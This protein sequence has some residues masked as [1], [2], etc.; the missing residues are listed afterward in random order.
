MADD[1]LLRRIAALED[2]DA[3]RTLKATYFAACDAKDAL[4]MRACFADGPVAIDYGPVGCFDTA[5]AVVEV[6]RQI[7][8][9]PHMVE[10]HHGSNPR[11]ELLGEGRAR[12]SWAL[13][14][15]LINTLDN[16]LTQ[17]AGYYEDEY[18]KEPGGWKIAATRVSVMSTLVLDL[19]VAGVRAIFAGRQPPAA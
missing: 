15:Q 11:I 18:R 13:H 6:F 12:G 16:Q 2:L 19:G 1:D 4:A 3:I 14:Y 17:L 7:G 8:C 10:L 5:D 9:H